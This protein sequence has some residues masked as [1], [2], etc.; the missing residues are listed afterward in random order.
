M[1]NL[2]GS[3]FVYLIDG[4]FVCSKVKIKIE[5]IV[6]LSFFINDIGLRENYSTKG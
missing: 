5:F 2:N 3:N 1:E 4:S 6:L